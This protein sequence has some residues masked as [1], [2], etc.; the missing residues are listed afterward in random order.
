MKLDYKFLQRVLQ[1][2]KN[3]RNRIKKAIAAGTLAVG[4]RYCTINLIPASQNSTQQVEVEKIQDI[5][6]EDELVINKSG[7][8]IEINSGILIGKQPISESSKSTLQVRNGD[9][10]KIG[11]GARAKADARRNAKNRRSGSAGIPAADGFV[12]SR[13]YC[14]YHDNA[15]LSCKPAVKAIDGP[16]KGDDNLPP[17]DPDSSDA[18]KNASAY[19]GGP[20]PFINDF[21]YNNPNHTRES[22]GFNDPDR[23]NHSYDGHA[24]DCFNITKNRNKAS[25][26]EFKQSLNDYIQAPET[27]RINGSYRYETPTYHYKKPDEDLVVTVNATNNEY[28]SVRNATE[29]QL[30]KME[31][32]GNLGLDHRPVM[33]LHLKGPNQKTN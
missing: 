21:N 28:I 33:S 12:P 32:D 29:F 26:A 17:P 18:V 30:E 5:I 10:D 4:L 2:I 15:P 11:P 31:I 6:Q 1:R 25:L 9:L 16:F 20:S 19:K 3:N 13:T 24:K 27:E 22:I 8:V 14:R 7:K 23:L